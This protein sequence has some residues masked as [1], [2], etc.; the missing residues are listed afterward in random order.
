ML[1]YRG[2]K[3]QQTVKDLDSFAINKINKTYVKQTPLGGAVTILISIFVLW[4]IIAETLYFLD[5][6]FVFTFV[7]D[8]DFDDKLKINLDI[9][10]AMPCHN[11]PNLPNPLTHVASMALSR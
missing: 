6:D 5:T 4:I 9:T 2:K 8:A 7:P 3:I 10:I 1:R 11:V